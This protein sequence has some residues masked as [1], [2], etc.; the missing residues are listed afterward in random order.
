MAGGFERR[1][2]DMLLS[3]LSLFTTDSAPTESIKLLAH[4]PLFRTTLEPL[5]D[6]LTR[7]LALVPSHDLIAPNPYNDELSSEL[8]GALDAFMR[9]CSEHN[10]PSFAMECFD[11]GALALLM[12]GQFA[13][14]MYEDKPSVAL[15]IQYCH[16]KCLLACER[17]SET[18]KVLDR[19]LL[20]FQRIHDEDEKVTI[21]RSLPAILLL[22]KTYLAQGNLYHLENLLFAQINAI[23][24]LGC[25]DEMREEIVVLQKMLLVFGVAYYAT[26]DAPAPGIRMNAGVEEHLG[27]LIERIQED[28]DERM[29]TLGIMTYLRSRYDKLW[30]EVRLIPVLQKI[31][32]ILLQV[33]DPESDEPAPPLVLYAVG[34]LIRSYYPLRRYDD[35]KKWR[36]EQVRQI[37]MLEMVGPSACNTAHAGMDGMD[38]VRYNPRNQLYPLYV[39]CRDFVWRDWPYVS[40][41]WDTI[42]GV[43][44]EI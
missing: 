14:G 2:T 44:L 1:D 37:S 35:I 22:A 11:K 12:S 10:E 32:S 41:P 34:G 28:P 21:R 4:N 26:Q 8:V 19:L 16:A 13:D 7:N 15:A 6:S 36:R 30:D 9:K 23:G 5:K 25:Y 18:E 31:E 20:S 3:S 39:V 33:I 40:L 27:A 24:G 38:A 29:F 17:Y 43:L 42:D